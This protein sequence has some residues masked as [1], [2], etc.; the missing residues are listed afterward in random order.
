MSL[1]VA[2]ILFAMDFENTMLLPNTISNSKYWGI[3]P[4]L[5]EIYEKS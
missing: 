5:C 2:P 1:I 3:L 4:L